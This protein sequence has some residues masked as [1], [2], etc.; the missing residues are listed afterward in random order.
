MHLAGA[1]GVRECPL[2]HSAAPFRTAWM[3]RDATAPP[4]CLRPCPRP[5]RRVGLH[6]DADAA[7]EEARQQGEGAGCHAPT[8]APTSTPAPTRLAASRT[9]CRLARP[10][11]RRWRNSATAH[12]SSSSSCS[13]SAMTAP[14][15]NVQKLL[16]D[17]WASGLDEAAVERDGAKPIAPL[18]GR[19]NAIKN[20]KDVPASIAALHQVGI[21]VAFNFGADIDL[22]GPRPP[23]R[24]LQ[25]GRPGPARS[26]LLHPQRCRHARAAGPVQ[27]L[28][29]EDPG[30]DRHAAGQSSPPKRSR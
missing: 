14:Q 22:E 12:A 29:A 28:R 24:L 2:L 18:L 7:E 19:I 9:R 23:H 20:A 5:A 21:P 3:I 26:R 8:P 10:R 13:T 17:F 6:P 4:A 25:P 15:G 27:R 16:G 11:C 1:H 30:A